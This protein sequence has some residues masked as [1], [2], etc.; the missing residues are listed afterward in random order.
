MMCYLRGLLPCLVLLMLSSTGFAAAEDLPPCKV[1]DYD[2]LVVANE[3]SEQIPGRLLEMKGDGTAVFQEEGSEAPTHWQK[4]QY[5]EVIEAITAEQVIRERKRVLIDAGLGD[6]R[7][8]EIQRTINFG[9][10]HEAWEASNAF[11]QAALRKRPKDRRLALLTI[12]LLQAQP[13]GEAELEQ[14]VRWLLEQDS[15]WPEGY[16]VLAQILQDAGRDQELIDL[17]DR[18]LEA[19]PT[20]HRANVIM[21]QH[22]EQ[23]GD[24]PAA[25]DAYRRAFTLHDDLD[26]G[27]GYAR[28]SLMLGDHDAALQAAD[29]LLDNGRAEADAAAV[30]GSA[31]LQRGDIA[32][33]EP[34]LERALAADDLDGDLQGIARYNLGLVRFRQGRRE[35]ALEQWQGIDAPV[36]KLARGIAQRRAVQLDGFENPRLRAI[37]HEHNASLALE[38]RQP[39]EALRLLGDAQSGRAGFLA[40]VARMLDE[41]GSEASLRVLERRSEA[42]GM[43][44]QV[45]GHLI[46]GRLDAAQQVLDRLPEDDGYAAVCRVYIAAAR[47]EHARAARLYQAVLETDD[48]PPDYVAKLVAEYEAADDEVLQIGFDWPEGYNMPYGWFNRSKGTG[49]RVRIDDGQLVL[50]GRQQESSQPVTMAWR[51]VKNDRLRQVDL[52]IDRSEAGAADVGLLLGDESRQNMLAYGVGPDGQYRW[53]VFRDG[54]WQ[55][56]QRLPGGRAEEGVVSLSLSYDPRLH[57]LLALV[58][59]EIA[60]AQD[61]PLRGQRLSVG[62]YGTAEPG[63]EWRLAVDSMEFQLRPD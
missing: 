26:A 37:A 40:L 35:A 6:D 47:E 31:H 19:S 21:A 28:T 38:R 51:F 49:V 8:F 53:R 14:T 12:Q 42:E 59:R 58:P 24:L 5:I 32:T 52:T 15:N 29:A 39:D 61:L 43:H 30:A 50:A 11:A 57:R 20:S 33:A 22:A 41:N 60:V 17:V 7:P 13:G 45:Y 23:Q 55:G 34:L 4:D 46:A 9:I 16:Q 2:V 54:R 25:R 48:A 18:W 56:W 1:R 63:S 10:K 36:A 27:L 3:K 44:W 62:V